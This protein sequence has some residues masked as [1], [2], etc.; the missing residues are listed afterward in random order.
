VPIYPVIAAI[1]GASAVGLGAFGA[2]GLEDMLT[3]T[4]RLD[5]WKTAVFYH[6]V[7]SVVL[8][9]VA[10]SSKQGADSRS[11]LSFWLFF[12]GIVVFSGTLYLLCLTG[13]TWL[14]AVTPIGGVALIAGWLSLIWTKQ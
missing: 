9:I 14:G 1:T 10:V 2:H 12:G 8:L 4:G 11:G 6:L 5:V 13:Q 3:E 7:H